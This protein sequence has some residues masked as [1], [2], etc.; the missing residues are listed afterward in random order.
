MRT[1]PCTRLMAGGLAWP[2]AS[3][4]CRPLPTVARSL[5]SGAGGSPCFLE[6]QV[7]TGG[8]PGGQTLG[9]SLGSGTFIRG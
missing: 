5:G 2:E 1:S 9:W 4:S 3:E 8:T 7:V 6:P